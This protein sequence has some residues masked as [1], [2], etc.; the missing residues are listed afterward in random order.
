MPGIKR[1]MNAVNTYRPNVLYKTLLAVF[2]IT[3]P[4]T[5]VFALNTWL[6]L[7]L[8][9]IFVFLGFYGLN[10]LY[11]GYVIKPVTCLQDVVLLVFLLSLFVASWVNSDIFGLKQLD[12]LFS[13][14]VVIGAYYFSARIL[15]QKTK[16][17]M[18]EI[19]FWLTIAV[20]IASLFG[21][22]EFAGKNFFSYDADLLV[23]R[24]TV[25]EYNPLFAG[26][27]IRARSFM[28]ESG[29]F[30]LF[31]ELFSPLIIMHWFRVKRSIFGVILLFVCLMALITTFSAAAVAGLSF[32]ILVAL[33][34]F[35][36]K[37]FVN[38]KLSRSGLK[39]LLLLF[40]SIIMIMYFGSRN[41]DNAYISGIT[42]KLVLSYKVVDA[43]NSRVSK[44]RAV[45]PVIAE[46]PVLGLGPGGF[47]SSQGSGYGIVS[48]WLQ[49]MVEGGLISTT[50]FFIFYVSIFTKALCM[51]SVMKYSYIIALSAGAVHYSVISDYWLPW[52]WFV[53][54]M[55]MMELNQAH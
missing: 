16:T 2:I 24:A 34:A 5:N 4:A 46:H 22:F 18:N 19:M 38:K 48:W 40:F 12:H 45:I 27:I 23:T 28:S 44:W 47:L 42:N 37:V 54:I 31:L 33:I 8:F 3:L 9:V 43:P 32:G 52:I 21:I 7:P 26:V 35:L 39:L 50:L 36:A 11:A 15:I 49:L 55:T 51:N 6:P 1:K 41:I 13:Y 10:I 53:F 17:R 30:A 14:S 29:N 25:L 20:I